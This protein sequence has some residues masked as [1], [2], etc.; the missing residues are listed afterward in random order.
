M[1]RLLALVLAFCMLLSITA[2][3]GIDITIVVNP[4]E[5]PVTE[6]I[7]TDPTTTESTTAEPTITEPP[8]TEP[9]ASKGLKFTQY[10]TFC[11]VSGIGTCTDTNIII[12]S[13]YNGLPVTAI[14]DFA[15]HQ[16]NSLTSIIISDSVTNIGS[17]AFGGCTNLTSVTITDNVTSIDIN[18]FSCC[19]SLTSITYTGT[20]EQWSNVALGT[21]WNFD[22]P[23]TQVICSNGTVSIK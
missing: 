18:A 5:P 4:T 9:P 16:C 8:T 21:D 11:E 19:T 23:A 10:D 15:F 20:M 13:E 1:K 2:C 22:V 3:S 17:G 6:P 14:A 12:P 7:T